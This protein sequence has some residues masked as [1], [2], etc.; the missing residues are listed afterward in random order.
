[1]PVKDV[2]GG[3]IWNNY[4]PRMFGDKIP[5]DK[6]V[7]KPFFFGGSQV[8]YQLGLSKTQYSGTSMTNCACRLKS[9]KKIPNLR[10]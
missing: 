9:V 5:A 3:L 6:Y 8:P 10:K 2:D 7:E 1:M 4:N